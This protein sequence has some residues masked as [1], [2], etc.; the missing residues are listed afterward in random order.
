[1]ADS[2]RNRQLQRVSFRCGACLHKFNREPE[3]VEDAPD[4]PIHAWRYFARCPECDAEAEQAWWERNLMKAHAMATGPRTEEGK[5]AVRKNLEGHPTPE[6][7]RRTRFNAIKHGATA[8]TATYYPARPGKYPECEGCEY[9]EEVCPQQV[10][11]LKKMELFM[12]VHVAMDSGDPRALNEIHANIQ[13]SYLGVLQ[14]MLR[15]VIA[16]GPRLCNQ[17]YYYDKDGGLHWVERVDDETGKMVPVYDYNAHPLLK[18]ISEWLNKNGLSLDD[19]ALTHKGQEDREIDMGFIEAE[20]ESRDRADEYQE[21]TV[22]SLEYLR[23]QIERGQKR[24]KGDPVLIEQK[25]G[26]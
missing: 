20:K 1:M 8:R 7:A 2:D 22:Q 17:A 9:R 12:Q 26:G 23:E 13:S 18:I 5:A 6:E 19:L 16:D 15:Q 3:R 21:R 24:L 11:C 14:D 10:A 25:G 4:D